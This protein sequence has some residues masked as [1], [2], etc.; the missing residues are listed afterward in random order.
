[1]QPRKEGDCHV[2]E[3]DNFGFEKDPAKYKWN[4]S[5]CTT[6]QAGTKASK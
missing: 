4:P 5:D 3:W 2:L 1:M 6:C